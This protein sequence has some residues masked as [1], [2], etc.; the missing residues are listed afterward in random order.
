MTNMELLPE[1]RLNHRFDI[2]MSLDTYE[3]TM[4]AIFIMLGTIN[5][6]IDE[7]IRYY[8]PKQVFLRNRIARSIE[9][10]HDHYEPIIVYITGNRLGAK[11]NEV[12]LCICISYE[13]ESMKDQVGAIIKNIK[14]N[15]SWVTDRTE[16]AQQHQLL[17]NVEIKG[18]NNLRHVILP[19]DINDIKSD[20]LTTQRLKSIPSVDPLE[21]LHKA[22]DHLKFN[23]ELCKIPEKK[24]DADK[25][26]MLNPE[27]LDSGNISYLIHKETFTDG[28]L[29]KRFLEKASS[30]LS[31]LFL[32]SNKINIDA[33]ND[34]QVVTARFLACNNDFYQSVKSVFINM[35]IKRKASP[36]PDED[37]TVAF[38]WV[39]SL[40]RGVPRNEIVVVNGRLSRSLDAFIIYSNDMNNK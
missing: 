21:I 7:D 40:E 4:D 13:L 32:K 8:D 20:Q 10:Y 18:Q 33:I 28:S 27:E 17:T 39:K 2:A 11:Y 25:Y 6:I 36:T 22:V 15:M 5:K 34:N 9:E 19:F 12:Y 35:D 14:M 3:L 38:S 16:F 24:S 29:S 31:W 30:L 23:S 1:L 37:Y 26:T